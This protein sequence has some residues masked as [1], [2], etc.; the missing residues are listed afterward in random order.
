MYIFHNFISLT[1]TNVTRLSSLALSPIQALWLVESVSRGSSSG[2]GINFVV[3][4][5][6]V[7]WVVPRPE[8]R[9]ASSLT[10]QPACLPACLCFRLCYLQVPDWLPAL[11]V[12][13]AGLTDL[14]VLD[15]RIDRLVCFDRLTAKPVCF[16]GPLFFTFFR[17]SRIR[18]TLFWW[19]FFILAIGSNCATLVKHTEFLSLVG[20]CETTVSCVSS[21][22]SVQSK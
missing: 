12:L 8:A 5:N 11:S 14:S 6:I 10:S 3:W 15:I 13:T 18:E 17:G 1:K 16:A 2:K 20:F 21:C 19:Y 7:S 4:E 22:S 9:P